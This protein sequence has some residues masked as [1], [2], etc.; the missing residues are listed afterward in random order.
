MNEEFY[1]TEFNLHTRVLKNSGF[2]RWPEF[3]DYSPDIVLPVHNILFDLLFPIRIINENNIKQ[4]FHRL[5]GT[6]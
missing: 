1:Q 5:F 4:P 2:G 6:F 3:F